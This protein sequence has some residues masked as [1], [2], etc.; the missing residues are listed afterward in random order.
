ML[1]PIDIENLTKY[2]QEVFKEVFASKEDFKELKQ[3]IRGLQ[4]SV[5]S[6]MKK[7]TTYHQESVVHKHTVKRVE[8]WVKQA[9]VKLG[10][11]Y[12]P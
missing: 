5:D 7:T 10:L 6:Y 9:A 3:D 1:T 12:N 4:T 2:Q 11:D 8:D